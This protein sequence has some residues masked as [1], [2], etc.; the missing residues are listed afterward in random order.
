MKTVL[1]P[2]LG[3]GIVD[4]SYHAVLTDLQQNQK[5]YHNLFVV[6]FEAN[7]LSMVLRDQEVRTCIKQADWIL[8]DGIAVEKLAGWHNGKAIE[9]ISGPTF[10]LKACEYGQALQWKHFFY[11]GTP[12]SMPILLNKLKK[13]LMMKLQD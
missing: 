5:K 4:A 9:R 11:G 13:Q 6:F 3:M 2:S 12:K 1:I 7:L 10:M 8:P